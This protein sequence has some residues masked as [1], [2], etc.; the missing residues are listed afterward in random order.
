M[1]VTGI[2]EAVD[3]LTERVRNILN[4]LGHEASYV[5]CHFCS[6]VPKKTVS[7]LALYKRNS[8]EFLHIVYN[9]TWVQ[10]HTFEIKEQFKQ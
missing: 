5:R 6:L 9:E 3:I 4:E 10:H 1:T 7:S 2:A 8:S